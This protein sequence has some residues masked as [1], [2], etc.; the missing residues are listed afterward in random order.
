LKSQLGPARQQLQHRDLD[1]AIGLGIGSRGL[2]I[3]ERER[4]TQTQDAAA[5][6]VLGRRHQIRNRLH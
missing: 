5:E 3:E 1:D 4:A 6:G 2:Q